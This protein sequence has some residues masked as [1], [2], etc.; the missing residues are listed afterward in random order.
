MPTPERPDRAGWYDDPDHPEQLRYFD[1]VVWTAHVTPRRTR[2]DAPVSTPQ[3]SDPPAGSASPAGA[4]P[5]TAGGYQGPPPTSWPSA[6]L[7]PVPTGPA[8]DGSPL[9]SYGSRAVAY[10]VDSIIVGVLSTVLGGW[11]LWKAMAPVMDSLTTAV[12]SGDPQQTLKAYE[13]ALNN[14]EM[15]WVIAFSAVQL[16]VQFLYRVVCLT[17]WSATPGKL[18]LGISVRRIDRRGVLDTGTAT[19][20]AGFETL[21]GVLGIIPLISFLSTLG[22]LADLL[23]PLADKQRQALHDKVAGTVVVRGRQERPVAPSAPELR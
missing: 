3:Q 18:L 20:R 14:L 2:W 15:K 12:Q 17:R 7:E 11:F 8:V 22:T 6:P 16:I 4:V 23:W 21:L 10:I 13:N 5:P 9:A 19:R 1:G